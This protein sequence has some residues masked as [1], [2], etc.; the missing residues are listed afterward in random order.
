MHKG[1]QALTFLQKLW[2]FL[3]DNCKSM[4]IPELNFD[5]N[6]KFF[7][8]L[9]LAKTM[10]LFK[11]LVPSAH[12]CMHHPSS[13]SLFK[14]SSKKF[15][16][17]NFKFVWMIIGPFLYKFGGFGCAT[18]WQKY[19]FCEWKN[20]LLWFQWVTERRTC[21]CTPTYLKVCFSNLIDKTLVLECC[22]NV[23]LQT[24]LISLLL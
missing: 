7:T 6:L 16:D 22:L 5:C 2:D 3:L 19:N 14:D 18:L 10:G 8:L 13:V 23:S 20:Q 21:W 11:F 15:L 17:F 4:S 24:S 9:C 12:Q 1:M